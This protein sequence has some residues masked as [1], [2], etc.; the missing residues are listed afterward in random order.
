MGRSNEKRVSSGAAV[1]LAQFVVTPENRSA[2]LAIRRL[3]AAVRNGRAPNESLP[4]YLDGPPG[5]GKSHLAA[6]LMAAVSEGSPPRTCRFVAA[7]DWP[8]GSPDLDSADFTESARACDLLI[9]ED[10]QHLPARAEN[11]LARIVDHRLSRRRA[12]VVTGN[13]G[14]APMR[15]LSSRVRSRLGAGL[16]VSLELPSPETRR[17]L[18]ERFAERHRLATS[19]GVIDWLAGQS[20]GG[21]RPLLGAIN[22]LAGISGDKA[23]PPDLP[24][25]QK[26]WPALAPPPPTP[27]IER[28]VR[29]VARHFSIET[30]AMSDRRRHAGILWPLQVAMFLT[31]EQMGLPWT[32]IGAAFGGRDASTVRHAVNKVAER[33]AAD[34]AT[35]SVLRQLRAEVA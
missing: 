9:V 2:L 23:R 19:P 5:V 1:R 33:E 20:T 10:I 21:L 17:Y 31:R 6:G 13:K 14:P 26:Q 34:F 27:S 28:I 3:A 32:R 12:F 22:T 7:G 18:L 15:H 25:V 8:A 29:Q 16:V 24:A 11:A 30:K 4:L 35:A